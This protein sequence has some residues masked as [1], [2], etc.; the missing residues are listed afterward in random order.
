[1]LL[2]PETVILAAVL[3]GC[4][5][6][7]RSFRVAGLLSLGMA[8]GL[9]GM[10]GWHALTT[11]QSALAQIQLNLLGSGT[12]GIGHWIADRPAAIYALLLRMDLTPWVSLALISCFAAGTATL[13]YAQKKKSKAALGL[14]FGVLCVWVAWYQYR[15]WSA[16][17]PPLALRGENSM[18]ATFPWVALLLMPPYRGRRALQLAGIAIL[19]AVA[20]VPIWEGVHWGPRLLLFTLPL[21]LMDL[22]RSD[23]V[24]GWA[25]NVLLLLT[26]IQGLSSAV[27]VYARSSEI[28]D[29][30]RYC[31]SYLGTPAI[32]PTTSE[33]ADL[34]ALWK[35]HEFF[36]TADAEEL[37]QL[38]IEFRFEK[39]DTAWLCLKAND[40]LYTETLPAA[41]PAWPHRMT[42]FRAGKL[43]KTQWRVLELVMNRSDSLWA[44]ILEGEAGRL[45]VT[46][47]PEAALRLQ[48]EAVAV[49]PASAQSHNNLAL[50]LAA[51]G[52]TIAACD[53]A[54]T[55]LQ[56]K[57]GLTESRRLLEM[58]QSPLPSAP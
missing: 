18:L 27:L 28:A 9:A 13:I 48:R 5:L 45:M 29:R 58:L 53:E 38:L 21:L 22:W 26:A 42:V 19:I 34:A 6:F 1:M 17:L 56:L 49:A 46:R 51:L 31:K 11:S 47:R 41:K 16:T 8:V 4:L 35:D 24:R 55:A 54:E 33:S 20:L 36:G 32:C 12:S 25:L 44:G 43:Y 40:P 52:D 37:R 23:L 50:I 10:F 3:I 2:R 14:A 30:I 57:P 39:L 15:L 7:R